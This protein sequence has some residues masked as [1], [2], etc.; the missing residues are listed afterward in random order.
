MPEGDDWEVVV[1]EYAYGAQ[2][3]IDAIAA[4]ARAVRASYPEAGR[5]RVNH[6]SR[7][8][9]G[10]LR[11]HRS[12]QS[13]R[14]VDLGL[15]YKGN[16][17]PVGMR[18]SREKLIDP[19]PNWA[20]LRALVTSSDVQLIL[21]DKRL[22]KV[23]YDHALSVGED[24]EWLDSLFVGSQA[25]VH[26]ARGHRDHFH[27]RFYCPRSQELGRRV[28]PLLAKRPD[29]NLVQYRVRSGDTLSHIARRFGTSVS[30][31]QKA[32]R[33]K[34][35][36]LSVARV[37]TIPLRGPCTRCPLPAPVAVPARRLPPEGIA[38]IETIPEPA[39]PEPTPPP[40]F[41]VTPAEI[42]V[43]G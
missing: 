14:D 33:M 30:A 10:Y 2:E 32:N 16:A 21:L 12:H 43:G 35:S 11:P 29:T 23:I 42:P 37:L 17:N 8:D 34:S 9:G 38:V 28:Q 19:S 26:H 6:I 41:T 20:L 15:F 36:F 5:L 40:P 7:K 39:A 18:G 25:L 31:I 4:V 22:Q 24:K 1:P 13:G 27:V 3:T